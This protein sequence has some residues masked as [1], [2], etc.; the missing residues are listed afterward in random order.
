MKRLLV[1][2]IVLVSASVVLTAIGNHSPSNPSLTIIE[3]KAPALA[4]SAKNINPQ[5]LKLA[6]NAYNCAVLKGMSPKQLLTIIDYSQPSARQRLWVFDVANN[7]MLFNT[8]VAH[9][10]GS[11]D[12]NAKRFSNNAQTHASSIGLFQTANIYQGRA[13]YSMRLNGLEPGFND[14]ALSRA[15][16]MHGASYVNQTLAQSGRIGRSWGCPAVPQA[17]AKPIINTISNGSLV[18]A[19]YPD[20]HWLK[21]SQYLNCPLGAEYAANVSRSSLKQDA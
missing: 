17:L 9:G 4:S 15:I 1:I 12:V 3:Q 8:F 21:K 10:Q 14:K 13:G 18:F 2:L 5:V 16:V 7:K 6:L 19:Y 20:S 11:G